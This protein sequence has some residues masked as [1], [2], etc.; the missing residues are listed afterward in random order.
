MKKFRRIFIIVID[1][2]GIGPMPDAADFG[3]AG[4]DTLGHISERAES[5]HIPNLQRLGLA[6]LKELKQVYQIKSPA[7]YYL[8]LIHI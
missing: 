6:N 7:G 8:S 2:L 4:A 5:F 1:S 3:D